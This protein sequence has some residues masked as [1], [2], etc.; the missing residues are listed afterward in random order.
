VK[1]RLLR[2]FDEKAA[3]KYAAAQRKKSVQ[4]GDPSYTFLL[5]KHIVSVDGKE[6]DASR[7]LSFCEDLYGPDSQAIRD[8]IDEHSPGADLQLDIECPACFNDFE[9]VMPFTSQFFRPK[10]S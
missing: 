2:V 7:A 5:S 3:G 4:E 6:V 9:S 10:R 1:L 8:C